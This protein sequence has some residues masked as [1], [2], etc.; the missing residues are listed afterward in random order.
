MRI[1][2]PIVKKSWMRV[3]N[4]SPIISGFSWPT[5]IFAAIFGEEFHSGGAR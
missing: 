4:W 1:A 5:I 3:I 2:S